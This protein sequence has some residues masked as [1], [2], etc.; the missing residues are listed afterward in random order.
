MIKKMRKLVGKRLKI[1]QKNELQIF[2][3]IENQFYKT[4]NLIPLTFDQDLINVRW[5]FLTRLIS[6]QREAA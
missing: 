1:K 5:S 6:P 2:V 4:S 3:E